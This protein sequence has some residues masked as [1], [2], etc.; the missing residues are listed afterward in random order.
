M[1]ED[2]AEVASWVRESLQAAGMEVLIAPDGQAALE[3]LFEDASGSFDAVVLDILLPRMDGLSVL[4]R[5][6]EAGHQ[7]PVILLTARSGLEDRVRGLNLG[8]DDYLPKPFFAEELVARLRAVARRRNDQSILL[9]GEISIDLLERRVTRAGSEV[10]LTSREFALLTC[11]ARSEGR[12]LTRTELC[13]RVWGYHHD[14]GTNLVDVYI[15]RLRRKLKDPQA[16]GLI[17]TV[18]GVGYRLGGSR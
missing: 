16:D 13:E 11:L 7:V 8:A 10:E 17:E 18:R 14:P 3:A 9:C 4:R 1:A 6:R 2:E 5:L 15:Q 12:V